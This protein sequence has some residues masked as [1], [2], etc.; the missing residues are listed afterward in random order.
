MV[1]NLY[2]KWRRNDKNF[3]QLV[4][5]KLRCLNEKKNKIDYAKPCELKYTFDF[6][7]WLEISEFISSKTRSFILNG[8]NKIFSKKFE[9]CGQ[10]CRLRLKRNQFMT[11]KK[12]IPGHKFWNGVFECE[13]CKNKVESFIENKPQYNFPITLVL[14]S[15]NNFCSGPIGKI[16]LDGEKREE[17]KFEAFSKGVTNFKNEAFISGKISFIQYIFI[18]FL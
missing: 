17:I 14:K 13:N 4:L 2:V 18:N 3:K 16:R 15:T 11:A 1:F 8:G 6:N 7:E 9:I 5:K 12:V 10:K